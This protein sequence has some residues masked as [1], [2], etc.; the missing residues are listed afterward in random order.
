MVRHLRAYSLHNILQ[1]FLFGLKFSQK[2]E[3]FMAAD[4][5]IKYNKRGDH[6]L[7]LAFGELNYHINLHNL[8]I[9]AKKKKDR[10]T[11]RDRYLPR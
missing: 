5:V 10:Q 3:H 11:D 7:F 6:T 2:E 9:C 4:L 8:K 1:W